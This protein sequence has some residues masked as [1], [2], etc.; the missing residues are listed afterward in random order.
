MFMQDRIRSSSHFMAMKRT[1]RPLQEY[2]LVNHFWYYQIT[3]NGDYSFIGS[4]NK[5]IDY[6]FESD[7]LFDFPCI[8]NPNSYDNGI[9]MMNSGQTPAYQEILNSASKQFSIFFQFQLMEYSNEGIRAF[10]FATEQNAPRV[11]N[12]LLNEMALLR[13]FIKYFQDENAQLLEFADN[14][15]VN[16]LGN[17]SFNLNEQD[18]PPRTEEFQREE[19]LRLLNP[20]A[21]KMRLTKREKEILPFIAQGFPASYIAQEFYLSRRTVENHWAHIKSKLGCETKTELIKAAQAYNT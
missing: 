21:G 19:L 8:N 4:N 18:Q 9:S 17:F 7:R 5:W 14:Q 20:L 6:V 15:A 11:A 12:K 16:L 13:S 10:G 3:K 2:F 1:L